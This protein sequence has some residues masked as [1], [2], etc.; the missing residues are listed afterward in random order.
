MLL[1]GNASFLYRT[2]LY[3]KS[4]LADGTILYTCL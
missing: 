2:G 3:P 4:Y 1:F